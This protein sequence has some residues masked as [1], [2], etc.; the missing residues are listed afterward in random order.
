[1][2]GTEFAREKERVA[3]I[4]KEKQAKGEKLFFF[5]VYFDI[6]GVGMRGGDRPQIWW[7]RA[8]GRRCWNTLMMSSHDN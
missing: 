4:M 3:A 5:F 6:L 2:T 7:K 8:I 1:M